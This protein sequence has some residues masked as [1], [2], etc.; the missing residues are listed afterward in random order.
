MKAESVQ[1][2]LRCAAFSAVS[3]RLVDYFDVHS[4]Q[5]PPL[6][7]GARGDFESLAEQNPPESPFVKG[8]LRS[9]SPP[10]FVADLNRQ[11]AGRAP[12]REG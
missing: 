4:L 7:R 3:V 2:Q 11:N 9:S 5:F 6:Q 10:E 1:G 12:R 8:G